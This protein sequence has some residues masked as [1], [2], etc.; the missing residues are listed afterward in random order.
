MM[1]F[2]VV[3]VKFKSI[4]NAGDQTT[5]G[6]GVLIKRVFRC[7]GR[8]FWRRIVISITSFRFKPRFRPFPAIS[9]HRLK[10]NFSDSFV[11]EMRDLEAGH[12]VDRRPEKGC[13]TPVSDA[14]ET[15][16]GQM[17]PS[18]E[19]EANDTVLLKITMLGDSET[20]KTSF[21]VKY[22][23]SLRNDKH[24]PTAGISCMEKVIRV[25]GAKIAFNIWDLG[26]RGSNLDRV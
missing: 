26:G 17:T 14:C 21:M 8:R 1:I 13:L 10:R 12:G 15:P 25:K 11:T 4:R 24:L 7:L 19:A 18:T 16:S 6:C 3:D 22:V 9:Y 23:S 20:G 5:A 2:K